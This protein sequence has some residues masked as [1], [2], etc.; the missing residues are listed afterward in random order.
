MK[1]RKPSRV[2][3]HVLSCLGYELFLKYLK[4]ALYIAIAHCFFQHMCA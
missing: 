1:N 4:T 2:D 3:F